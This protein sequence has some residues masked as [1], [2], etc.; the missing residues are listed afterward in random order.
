M[1]LPPTA[2][3]TRAVLNRARRSRDARFDGRFFVA[4]TTTGIYCRPVCPAPSPRAVNVLYFPSAAAAADAGFR[5]CLRCRPEAAPG[6][7]AWLGTS[8][9]VRRAI[10]LIHEGALDDG[11]VEALA[12]RVGIGPRHLNRLFVAHVGAPPV[13]VAQTHR[14]HFAKRLLDETDLAMAQVAIASGFRSLRRFNAAFL[15]TYDRPPSAVRR[16]RAA[17]PSRATE[18]LAL[19]LA[20][21]SPY[22]LEGLLGFLGARAL[23]GVERVD[24]ASYARTVALDSGPAIVR[25]GRPTVMTG[26]RRAAAGAGVEALELRVTGAPATALLR[27]TTDARRAFDLAADPAEVVAA[28]GADPLLGPLVRRRPGLR[29]AGAWDPFECGVRAVLGQ[30]VSVAA[31]RTLAVRLVDRAGTRLPAPVDGLTHVFPS[32]AAVATA[33]L[34]GLGLTAARA[35]SITAL[36]RAVADG[37]L[38]L[39]GPA[40]EVTAGLRAL[41]GFGSWTAQYIALRALGEP[42]AFP[43]GDLVLRRQAGGL[44]ERALEARAEPWRPWRGYAVFHLWAEASS[45]RHERSRRG[46]SAHGA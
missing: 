13:A 2:F 16:R 36:A 35:A 43:S 19:R 10:A 7:P 18:G 30:Q 33:D 15:A 28:F 8:A 27:L 32:P 37:R 39:H 46:R 9:V 20:V 40:D 6:T 5:P 4:V 12:A 22:D 34:G 3:P 45:T 42:D 25:V 1:D 21:R 41:P 24:G 11:S 44:T 14:L 31:A 26:R 17:A 29:I 23:P 38:D